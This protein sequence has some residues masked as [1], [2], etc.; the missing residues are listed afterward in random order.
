MGERAWPGYLGKRSVDSDT[1]T[2]GLGCVGLLALTLAFMVVLALVNGY[3]VA[4][5]WEWF[6][7]PTFVS[8]PHLSIPAAIGIALIVRYLTAEHPEPEFKGGSRF[9]FALSYPVLALAVG[10]IVKEFM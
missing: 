10:W 9:A 8:A 6:V 3:V 4:T 7:E 2:D 5:L 1:L